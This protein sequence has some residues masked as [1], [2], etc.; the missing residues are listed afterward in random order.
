MGEGTHPESLTPKFNPQDLRKGGR[1]ELTP[2]SH[3]LTSTNINKRCKALQTEIHCFQVT[4][5]PRPLPALLL[6]VI[7]PLTQDGISFLAFISSS[8]S[9]EQI[10]TTAHSFWTFL[11]RGWSGTHYTWTSCLSRP[12]ARVIGTSCHVQLFLA[13]T[14]SIRHRCLPFS[15][16]SAQIHCPY[17]Y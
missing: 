6:L 10:L 14:I 16:P 8:Y 15:N 3:P 2:W 17:H 4:S 9:L 1:R 11:F 13:V 12:S 7:S 5:H